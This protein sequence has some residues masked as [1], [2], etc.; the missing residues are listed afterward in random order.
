MKTLTIIN[1]ITNIFLIVY[2]FAKFKKIKLSIETER[3]WNNNI[4]CSVSL[5][6]WKY[7]AGTR[8]FHF[9]IRNSEKIRIKEEIE[10]MLSP[11]YPNTKYDLN[12]KLS[13]TKNAEEII[14]FKKIYGKVDPEFVDEIINKQIARKG[15]VFTPQQHKIIYG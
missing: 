7:G 2:L 14:K 8:L 4:L 1:T 15:I 12:A 6:F 13:W 10:R 3:S 11:N 5:Y 9:Q